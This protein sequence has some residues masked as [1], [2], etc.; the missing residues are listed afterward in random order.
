[1]FEDN[2][3]E[4]NSNQPLGTDNTNYQN[5][6]TP[7]VNDWQTTQGTGSSF[8]SNTNTTGPNNYN[9]GSNVNSYEWGSVANKAQV[10]PKKK[11]KKQF[12]I[13]WKIYL[14]TLIKGNLFFR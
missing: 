3:Y 9:T 2:R 1:M 4:N 5:P 12:L 7:N 10:P 8:T 11:E 6:Q 13:L 14:M